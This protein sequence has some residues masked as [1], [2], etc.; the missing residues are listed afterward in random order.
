MGTVV[1][2]L[3]PYDHFRVNAGSGMHRCNRCGGSGKIYDFY[4]D[5][6]GPSQPREKTKRVV[7][8]FGA[9]GAIYCLAARPFG[10]DWFFSAALGFIVGGMLAGFASEHR[11][12]RIILWIIG[13]GFAS[14]IIA[15]IVM[16]GGK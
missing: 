9:I 14:L 7:W 13:V 11:I 6:D 10:F 15:G 3:N 16:S 2:H 8:V 4:A 12:G 1:S 5:P